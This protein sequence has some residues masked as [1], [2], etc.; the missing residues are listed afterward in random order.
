M[1]NITDVGHLENDADEGEDGREVLGL[2]EL[3]EEGVKVVS[4]SLNKL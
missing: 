4:K 2:E 3:E 1:R